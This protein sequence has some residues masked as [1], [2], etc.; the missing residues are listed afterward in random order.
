MNYLIKMIFHL[1][2][3][4]GAR[5]ARKLLERLKHYETCPDLECQRRAKH[6]H[7][8]LETMKFVK[9]SP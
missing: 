8:I 2:Y 6:I 7:R 9:L 3:P 1:T 4:C 5:K